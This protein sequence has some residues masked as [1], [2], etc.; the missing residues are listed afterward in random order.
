MKNVQKN[1]YLISY[2]LHVNLQFDVYKIRNI[3][4]MS[5]KFKI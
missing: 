4:F 5:Y 2:I 3:I 1:K